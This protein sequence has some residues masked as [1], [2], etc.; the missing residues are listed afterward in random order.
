MNDLALLAGALVEEYS[1]VVRLVLGRACS[2]LAVAAR[3]HQLLVDL[4]EI[5]FLSLAVVHVHQVVQLRGLVQVEGELL[6][7]L[8]LAP[9]RGV[10][11]S[12]TAAEELRREV[13]LPRSSVTA[14]APP[15]AARNCTGAVGPRVGVHRAVA[16]SLRGDHALHVGLDVEVPERVQLVVLVGVLRL[17]RPPVL[18]R[19]A[20]SVVGVVGLGRLGDSVP[21]RLE[22]RALRPTITVA[23]RRQIEGAS[24]ARPATGSAT[25]PVLCGGRCRRPFGEDLV[26]LGEIEAV[27]LQLVLQ[28]L[29]SCGGDLLGLA[30]VALHLLV[31]LLRRRRSM[32]RVCAR[33]RLLARRRL[34]AGLAAQAPAGV[35]GPCLPFAIETGFVGGAL[36]VLRAAGGV[37]GVQE[38]V[39]LVAEVD[40]HILWRLRVGTRGAPSRREGG[41][42][43][44]ATG[45]DGL[46]RGE[47][48][49]LA[50]LGG[51][52]HLDIGGLAE[53][54]DSLD[55]VIQ[56]PHVLLD[57]LAV[58]LLVARELLG[59]VHCMRSGG[60]S[61]TPVGL[62]GSLASPSARAL[63]RL[64]VALVLLGS[65][66]GRDGRLVGR[67]FCAH[68]ELGDLVL[69]PLRG[70]AQGL[71]RDPRGLGVPVGVPMGLRGVSLGGSSPG[72]GLQLV[73]DTQGGLLRLLLFLRVVDAAQRG[74]VATLRLL[75]LLEDADEVLQRLVDLLVLR[76]VQAAR[77]KAEVAQR[78]GKLAAHLV[79]DVLHDEVVL[80]VGLHID[81]LEIFQNLLLRGLSRRV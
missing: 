15:A 61:P 67:A 7:L 74:A 55:E 40:Q 30:L 16:I 9:L 14:R 3:G 69:R 42:D 70:R 75:V 47:D 44:A 8:T 19:V 29:G 21:H 50:W 65:R 58:V 6:A 68:Q 51:R 76:R 35:C 79:A 39:Q 23:V 45:G 27:L 22:L 80:V 33:L 32:M 43:V 10:E 31:E 71:L 48:L 81:L 66:G 5:E 2:F 60:A 12:A 78:P 20:G 41:L 53:L 37:L 72:L 54:F 38:L 34:G 13:D 46:A 59:L 25:S 77:G 26:E 17:L 52:V 36:A 63:V 11:S 18:R 57:L 28:A 73:H 64:E 62:G 49:R 24:P 56:V 4:S 1:C